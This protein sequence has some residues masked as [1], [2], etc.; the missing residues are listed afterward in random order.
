MIHQTDPEK[1]QA[2][3]R[4]TIE[5]VAKRGFHATPMAMIAARAGVGAGSI[6]RYFADK[7]ILIHETFAEVSSRMHEAMVDG[8]PR[9]ESIR[10]RYEHF[11]LCMSHFFVE[12]SSDF[13]FLRQYFDSPFG[14]ALR[15]DKMMEQ[16]CRD[17]DC[18]SL[19]C[20][21]EEGIKSGHFKDLPPLAHI[22]IV[23]GSL[24]SLARDHIHG[25][26]TLDAKMIQLIADACWDA[27]ARH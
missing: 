17:T 15:R 23:F 4:A 26:L 5:L 1:R 18:E 20:L 12:N 21:I 13:A 14:T 2:I 27:L 9:G 10:R 22:C 3:L 16:Q 25:F 19:S 11:F 6:Y 24:T 7:E 8:Y